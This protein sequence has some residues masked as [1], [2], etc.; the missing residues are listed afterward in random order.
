MY[1]RN[2]MTLGAVFWLAGWAALANSPT[3]LVG[4]VGLFTTVV[5]A[6]IRFV[7]GRELEVRFGERHREYRR[8][9]PFLLPR[10]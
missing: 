10:R 2:P 6:Y 1:T 9:T 4:G 3:G 8:R 7:E 5:V